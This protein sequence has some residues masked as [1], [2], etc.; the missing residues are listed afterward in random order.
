VSGGSFAEG[1]VGIVLDGR[2]RL[3]ALLGE[4]GMGAVFRAHHLPTDRRVAVKLLKPHL[5]NDDTA[6]ERFARVARS[7]MRVESPHAVKV[8]DFG[9]TPQRDYY[10]ALEYVDGRTV[11]REIEIDGPFAPA[12]V[13][14]IARQALHALDAAHAQGLVHRDIKPE[15]IILTSVDGDNDFAKLLDFGVAK[16]MQG[17]ARSDRSAMALTQQGM[18]FGTCEFMSPEQACG[19]TVDGR[20]DLYSL[21]ATMFGMLTGCGMFQASSPL[22]WLMAHARQPPPH[23]TDVDPTFDKIPELDAL[24]QRCFAKHREQRPQTAQELSEL[25]ANI[26]HKLAGREVPASPAATIVPGDVALPR[27]PT[28]VPARPGA[29][30]PAESVYIEALPSDTLEPFAARRGRGIWL[31]VGVLAVVGMIIATIVVATRKRDV[32]V[33][34]SASVSEGRSILG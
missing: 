4:G 5:T 31:A 23:L 6:L 22:E 19:Q 10:M 3:D 14:H 28:T 2:Y 17:A 29:A 26:E 25:I 34:A 7:T 33:S 32:S 9:I 13:L 12:R 20:S 30:K 27:A 11:Q 8:L 16:L 15:N 21:A 1:L 18:V 24:L